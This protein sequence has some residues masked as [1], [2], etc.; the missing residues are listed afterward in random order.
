MLEKLKKGCEIV[1]IENFLGQYWKYYRYLENEVIKTFEYS[2][3]DEV[4]KEN[5]SF[6]YIHLIQTICSEFD[7]VAKAYCDFLGEQA[8]SITKYGEVILNRYPELKK[9]IV[10]CLENRKLEYVPFQDWNISNEGER[11]SPMWWTMYN[12]VKHHR[13]SIN[14]NKEFKGKE[15]YKLANQEFVMNALSGLYFLEMY[16][17]KDISLKN[18]PDFPYIPPY[19]S[20]LFELKGW[21]NG[22]MLSDGLYADTK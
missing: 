4:N 5:F 2:A 6:K 7:V 16:F 22:F 13:N 3:L 20:I 19:P 12:K 1:K 18:N 9:H 11:I 17:Y 14:S 8:N 15:N 10:Y 21:I